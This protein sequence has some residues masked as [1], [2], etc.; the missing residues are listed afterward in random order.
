[1]THHDLGPRGPFSELELEPVTGKTNQLR[2]HL[3]HVGHPIVGDKKY[4]PDEEVFLDWYAHRDYARLAERLLLPRQALHCEALAFT[5][6]FSGA[7]LETRAPAAMW[8]DKVSG[9]L[10]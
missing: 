3:A 4:H 8:R 6:P 9:L 5:H 2:V 10:G 1:V 7:A